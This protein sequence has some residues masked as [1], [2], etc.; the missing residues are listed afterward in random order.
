MSLVYEDLNHSLRAGMQAEISDDIRTGV[1]YMS[2]RLT[3]AGRSRWP[4][5]LLDAAAKYDDNWLAAEVRVLL[6]QKETSTSSKGKI[7]EKEVP[8]NAHET[9][10][11]GEFNRYYI[12]AACL[13]A[14]GLSSKL[15]VYRGKQVEHPRNE[16]TAML[17]RL[18]DPHSLLIDLRKSNGIESSLGLPPG[19]NSGLTVRLK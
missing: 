13:T 17:G 16:S 7:F 19:P 14:I 11:E 4:Q 18:M 3:L 6:N 8:V 9:L 15:E 12:R 5:L 2:P 10:A 1:L